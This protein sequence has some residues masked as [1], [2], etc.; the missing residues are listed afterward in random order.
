[1]P[2]SSMWNFYTALFLFIVFLVWL[3]FYLKLPQ[4]VFGNLKQWVSS[5]AIKLPFAD[6]P[7]KQ[8]R[9]TLEEM[10]ALAREGIELARERERQKNEAWERLQQDDLEK[11]VR[12]I[13]TGGFKIGDDGHFIIEVDWLGLHDG[14]RKTLLFNKITNGDYGFTIVGSTYPPNSVD[15]EF[16]L[17]VRE[18]QELTSN[19]DDN[20]SAEN[21]RE[22][23]SASEIPGAIYTDSLPLSARHDDLPRLG[24]GGAIR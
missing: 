20:R 21:G 19:D 18:D 6:E 10:Q 3:V 12:K 7:E 1:M 5:R 9:L 15:C 22:S 24:T 23:L 4:K 16:F 2:D 8:K 14:N 11:L 13:N 17:K